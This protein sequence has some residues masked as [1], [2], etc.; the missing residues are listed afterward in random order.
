MISSDLTTG[1]LNNTSSLKSFAI[2]GLFGYKN[3]VLPLDSQ[4]LILIAENGW[5]KT[6]ILNSLYSVLDKNLEKLKK[7]DFEKIQVK[8]EMTNESTSSAIIN[9]KDIESISSIESDED[10]LYYALANL[11]RTRKFLANISQEQEVNK[12]KKE[13][14]KF[15]ERI[16]QEQ[17]INKEK[18]LEWNRFIEVIKDNLKQKVFYFPT[19]RRI[20]EDLSS[21]GYKDIKFDNNQDKLIQFGMEDVKNHFKQIEKEIK[22]TAFQLFSKVTG[23]MLTQFIDGIKVT[24]EMKDRIKPDILN[25]ILSRVGEQNISQAEQENIRHLVSSGDIYDSRYDDLIYFL[26]KLIN[27]Y[28][29][30]RKIDESIK[31]FAEVCNKYLR[32]TKE[33]IYNES[34]ADIDIKQT[35]NNDSIDLSGL[36]SGEKQIISLFSKVYLESKDNFI[37]IIDEP[38]LSLSVEW[39]QMLLPDI[40][41]SG[42]CK[43]LI[44]ATHSP[45]IFDNELDH[46]TYDLDQFVTE[47]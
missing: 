14:N 4:V 41:E 47:H 45:F 33:I 22:D 26:S 44:A 46:Y 30:Q 43:L 19:Y 37:L 10:S 1:T 35:R 36:S 24:Q 17:E 6:T 32:P 23:E 42:R 9:K 21:L 15:R 31:K 3:V 11:E 38:E 25:I 20:E 5:G 28:E 40:I 13:R 29:Q 18:K 12:E 7:V 27:L 39:Q 2:Y 8:F 16:S 34:T